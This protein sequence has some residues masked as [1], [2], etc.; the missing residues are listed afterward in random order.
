MVWKGWSVDEERW[1]MGID[2]LMVLKG[3]DEETVQKRIKGI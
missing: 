2:Q 3:Y 1:I